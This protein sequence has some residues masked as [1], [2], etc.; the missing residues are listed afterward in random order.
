MQ[1]D[2]RIATPGVAA[3]A[4]AAAVCKDRRFSDHAPLTMDCDGGYSIALAGRK[5]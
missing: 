2:Y 1:T 3:K 4:L 5:R